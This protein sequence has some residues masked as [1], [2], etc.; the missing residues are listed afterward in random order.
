MKKDSKNTDKLKKD[1]KQI[2]DETEGEGSK[3]LQNFKNLLQK[4]QGE[5]IEELSKPGEK[6]K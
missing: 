3:L 6:E 1:I 5:L 4:H 2:L